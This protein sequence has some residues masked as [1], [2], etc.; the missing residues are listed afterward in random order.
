M[1]KGSSF[2]PIDIST[3]GHKIDDLLHLTTVEIGIAFLLVVILLISFM[4]LYRER[5]GHKAF[6]DHGNRWPHLAL[7]GFLALC[8][9]FFIDLNIANLSAKV[10]DELREKMPDPDK[11]LTVRVL[12]QQY[13]WNFQYAGEDGQFDTAD[14]I[15]TMNQLHIP[16]HQ[17]VIVEMRSK[18]VIHSFNLPNFRLKQDVVP[19]MLTRLWFEATQTGEFEISCAE[20][21]GLGHYRMRAILTIQDNQEFKIWLQAKASEKKPESTQEE[22]W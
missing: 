12:A 8:V 2:F 3:N 11:S 4:I 19:G 15:A 18:D 1:L 9:Y 20:L 14:D 21:C 16:V 6:Y 10:W 22:E 5:T 13:A 7:T 17:T